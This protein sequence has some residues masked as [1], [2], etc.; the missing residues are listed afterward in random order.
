MNGCPRMVIA[1]RVLRVGER[2]LSVI[3]YF[4]R[5]NTSN[6]DKKASNIA[7]TIEAFLGEEDTSDDFITDVVTYISADPA[8]DKFVVECDQLEYGF[9]HLSRN[10]NCFTSAI[11]ATFG[12]VAGAPLS[13]AQR[14]TPEALHAEA[15]DTI[16]VAAFTADGRLLYPGA[17]IV[18]ALVYA[19]IAKI[20]SLKY[21]S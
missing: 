6:P 20:E 13:Q 18:D 10:L 21:L 12:R 9:D 14:A 15:R 3:K 1:G 2:R 7:R 19:Q 11:P 8:L 17:S 16:M 5:S 4:N